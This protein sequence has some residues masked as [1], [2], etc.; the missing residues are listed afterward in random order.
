[1]DKRYIHVMAG[2]IE[3]AVGEILIAR[4]AD[5]AH[6]GGLWEFPGGKREAGETPVAALRRELNEELGIGVEACRPQIQIHHDYGDKQILLDVWR[7]TSFSGEAHGREGQPVHWVKPED[8]RNFEFPAANKPIVTAARLP[9][10]YWITPEPVDAGTLLQQLERVLASGVRLVQLR[11]KTLNEVDLSALA[12]SFA[13]RCREHGA[14]W[15]VNGSPALAQT[16]GAD[17]VHL[18]AASLMGLKARPTGLDWLAASCHNAVE[19][20]QAQALACDFVTL[21]PVLATTSHPSAQP[22][23]WQRFAELVTSAAM[24]IYA[25]GGLSSAELE[26]AWACGAQGIAG[27]TRL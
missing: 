7:V 12:R 11:A 26:Q 21:S 27:I 16:L 17:G 9:A 14:R 23:A 2:V 24:P 19:L 1:M 25:L 4:R 22:L 13:E 18:S 15:L 5:K 10:R 20:A 8:L 3:N 6:Q